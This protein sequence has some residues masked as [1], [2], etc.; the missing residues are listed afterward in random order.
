MPVLNE[1][2]LSYLRVASQ[3]RSVEGWRGRVE[4]LEHTNFLGPKGQ[5]NDIMQYYI[6]FTITTII[7]RLHPYNVH[8]M[9]FCFICHVCQVCLWGAWLLTRSPCP[10]LTPLNYF[11]MHS[12]LTINWL[13]IT[14]LTEP[15]DQPS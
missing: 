10:I 7:K 5:R 4:L 1:S 6:M 11:A 3:A 13:T 8:A 9:T 2:L 15:P 12:R 14:L